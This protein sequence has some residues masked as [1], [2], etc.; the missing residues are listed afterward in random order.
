MANVMFS[1][2]YLLNEWRN[3]KVSDMYDDY[4][5]ATLKAVMNRVKVVKDFIA[6]SSARECHA[7]NKELYCPRLLSLA[8]IYA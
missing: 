6:L 3:A 5:L 4:W 7:N 8:M 1:V 2:K